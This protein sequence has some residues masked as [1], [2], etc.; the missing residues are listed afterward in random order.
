MVKWLY[1][2]GFEPDIARFIEMFSVVQE[3]ALYQNWLNL[4]INHENTDNNI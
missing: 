1:E 2:I 3:E 4:I